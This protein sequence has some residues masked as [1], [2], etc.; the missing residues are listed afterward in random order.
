MLARVWR[1]EEDRY[2]EDIEAYRDRLDKILAV[3]VLIAGVL[4]ALAL[5]RAFRP[6]GLGSPTAGRVVVNERRETVAGLIA[7]PIVAAMPA[8]PLLPLQPKMVLG[9]HSQLPPF[10]SQRTAKRMAN[11]FAGPNRGGL[12]WQPHG[13][14]VS[15]VPI[16][17][18]EHAGF[19][20][21]GY[22][23]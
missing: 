19:T 3:L 16:V 21:T 5:A 17:L 2:R 18:G 14:P 10:R 23:K 6:C 7:V 9:F 20:V 4:A 12:L 13:L 15:E 22:R 8:P 1:C 11:P